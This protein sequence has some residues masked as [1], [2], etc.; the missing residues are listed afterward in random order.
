MENKRIT[1][2]KRGWVKWRGRIFPRYEQQSWTVWE[3]D[4]HGTQFYNFELANIY[5]ILLDI[6][7]GN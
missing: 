5:A 7:N 1:Y 2:N 3:D 6:K 4:K